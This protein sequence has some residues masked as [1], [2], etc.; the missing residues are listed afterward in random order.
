MFNGEEADGSGVNFRLILLL[1]HDYFLIEIVGGRVE[2]G[3]VHR[4]KTPVAKIQ[5]KPPRPRTV[6]P[7]FDSHDTHCKEIGLLRRG[8]VHE[9]ALK[10]YRAA[11]A[12]P[13]SRI[14][15]SLLH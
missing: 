4:H 15:E 2:L 10:W 5:S 14:P 1:G 3:T 8:V 13:R 9:P 11:S 12:R 7:I 6:F